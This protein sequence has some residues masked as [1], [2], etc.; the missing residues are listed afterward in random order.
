VVLDEAY[1]DF[2]DQPSFCRHVSKYPHLVVLQTLSKAFGLAG[3]RLGFAVG[4]REIIGVMNKVK[5]PYNV[6]CLT[7]ELAIRMLEAAWLLGWF[8]SCRGVLYGIE[9]R[10]ARDFI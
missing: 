2:A 7:S 4:N 10:G 1:I 6:N 8:S 5:A 9:V 3:I